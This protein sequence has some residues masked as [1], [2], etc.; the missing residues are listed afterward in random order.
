MKIT[1]EGK[2]KEI[3]A[4]VEQMKKLREDIQIIHTTG[5]KPGVIS[6]RHIKTSS[7][8]INPKTEDLDK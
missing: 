2:A 3:A 1:I 7:D 4:L 5:L 6:S 8:Y